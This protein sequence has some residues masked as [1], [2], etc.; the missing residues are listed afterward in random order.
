MKNKYTIKTICILP[1]LIFIQ[2]C[3]DFRQIVGKEKVIPDEYSIATT[4]TLI[5]PPGRNIDPEI[6]KDNKLVN[7]KGNFNLNKNIEIMNT[8]NVSSFE[9]VFNS[10]NITDEIR[11]VVNEETLGISLSERRGIDILF[12]QIPDAGIVIEGKKEALR[13]KKIKSLGQNNNSSPT[14]GV[15]KN[16]GKRILIK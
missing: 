14:P 9:N 10:K 12:G 16:S 8:N 2:S 7:S 4:P 3:S 5:V 6:F 15:K 13:I 1:F 11:N